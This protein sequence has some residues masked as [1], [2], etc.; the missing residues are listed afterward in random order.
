MIRVATT[1]FWLAGDVWGKCKSSNECTQHKFEKGRILKI[2]TLKM[3]SHWASL[4]VFDMKEQTVSGSCEAKRSVNIRY[5]KWTASNEMHPS[6]RPSEPE[7]RVVISEN[8][9]RFMERKRGFTKKDAAFGRLPRCLENG[10]GTRIGTAGTW[11][12][13]AGCEN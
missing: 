1:M 8:D 2:I 12:P 3:K 13:A 7:C 4:F 5:I 9:Q 6:W 11:K 10:E